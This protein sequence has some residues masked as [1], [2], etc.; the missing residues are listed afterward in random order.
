MARISQLAGELV[1]ASSMEQ[2][3]ELMQGH[4]NLHKTQKPSQQVSS[5][6]T[7]Q[8]LSRLGYGPSRVASSR[9]IPRGTPYNRGRAGRVA[10]QG[11]RNRTLILNGTTSRAMG[12]DDT[13]V[14]RSDEDNPEHSME[15]KSG[16]V[17][18]RD[19]HMQL[20]NSSVFDRETHARSKAIEETRRQKAQQRDQR[21]KLKI[22]KHLQFLSAA[23]RP[24]ASYPT[25]PESLLHELIINGI[26]FQV[27][28]G[29]SK[30]SRVAGKT[31]RITE[32]HRDQI[33][34]NAFQTHPPLHAQRR[35]KLTLVVSPSCE[36]RMGISIAQAS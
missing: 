32:T 24:S 33:Q 10:L 22:K 4:I 9:R 14:N 16:W 17:T 25:T 36:V 2:S 31:T 3:A 13:M 20:I 21:E 34:A 11:H 15:Q 7:S 28:D 26:H 8:S 18:K 6:D 1:R 19:R 29:G 35:S 12:A 30:L 23:E 5:Y 27:V